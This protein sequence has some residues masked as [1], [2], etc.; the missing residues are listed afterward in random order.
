ME[1]VIVKNDQQLKDA[2]F[3]RTEVFI[4][5][6]NVSPEEEM[7]H[8]DQ[9]SSHLVIYDGK[10][11]VGAGRLRIV[12]GY[13]KLERI[14]VLQN[15]RSLGVGNLIMEALENEAKKLG[16]SQYMLNAQTQAVPFY[17][18]HGYRVVSEEFLDANIPHVKM[19]KGQHL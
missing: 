18:K 5:E 8:L 2:F 12:D 16:A 13:G 11:P 1:P 3:V 9:E 19:V 6:Q 17:E 10:E 15:Y 7:D 14:C 4:K